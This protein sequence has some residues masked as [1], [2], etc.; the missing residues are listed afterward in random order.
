M[1]K[2]EI[3]SPEYSSSITHF[4][5][6]SI[7]IPG[8]EELQGLLSGNAASSTNYTY[9]KI[10]KGTVPTSLAG[11]NLDYRASD[12]LMRFSTGQGRIPSGSQDF[13]VSFPSWHEVNISS[14][15]LPAVN[16]GT[17]TWFL[18]ESI[19]SVGNICHQLIGTVGLPNSGADLEL[20][21]TTLI[22]GSS[23]HIVKFYINFNYF[24]SV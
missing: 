13:S 20:S 16:G 17:A 19:S 18:L 11:F 1:N 4:N 2:V 15:V 24:W 22:Q 10:M 3:Y 8:L 12:E 21:N 9:I 5:G 14:N 23:Y 6:I 7:A